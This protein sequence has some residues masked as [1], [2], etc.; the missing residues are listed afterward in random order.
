MT[1]PMVLHKK[2]LVTRLQRGAGWE[3][4]EMPGMGQAQMP[5]PPT[6]ANHEV[7]WDE[8]CFADRCFCVQKNVVT[9]QA[10]EGS[11]QAPG[12]GHSAPDGLGSRRFPGGPLSPQPAEKA[13]GVEQPQSHSRAGALVHNTARA[14]CAYG[15]TPSPLQVCA[16]HH[17]T[18]ILCSPA[19]Q[20]TAFP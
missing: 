20:Q 6:R 11:A 9:L 17:C 14:V 18:G 3:G 1:E 2:G 5:L 13:G 19:Q 10:L 16:S 12:L 7:F 15:V 4:R 8:R